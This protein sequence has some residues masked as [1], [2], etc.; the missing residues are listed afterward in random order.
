MYAGDR[1]AAAERRN[2][3]QKRL[4]PSKRLLGTMIRAN[5]LVRAGSALA[6]NE[7]D[8][9]AA[10]LQRVHLHWPIITS[11][12]SVVCSEAARVVV[13]EFVRDG[14][15]VGVDS[16]PLCTATVQRLAEALQSGELKDVRVVPTCDA[17]S[18]ECTF[19]GVP[20]VFSADHDRVRGWRCW[21]RG[22][23]LHLPH[24]YGAI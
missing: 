5:T 7:A 2:R 12:L 21:L 15:L 1:A 11:G 9:T 4:I 24:M 13:S 17:A 22:H 19:V 14:M 10:A 3:K 18:Q 20:Q 23:S 8:R 6:N 16:G